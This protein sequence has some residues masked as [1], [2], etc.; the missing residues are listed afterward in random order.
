[1]PSV[2]SV[3]T[4]VVG[5]LS[6][7]PIVA[8]LPLL[9]CSGG[10]LKLSGYMNAGPLFVLHSLFL[11][12]YAG[13]TSLKLVSHQS[14]RTPIAL[15]VASVISIALPT[16]LTLIT[17]S[18]EW[19]DTIAA[20]T[21]IS[22][23]LTNLLHPQGVSF[24]KWT[25]PL[26]VCGDLGTYTNITTIFKGSLPPKGP[27]SSESTFFNPAAALVMQGFGDKAPTT[28]KTVFFPVPEEYKKESSLKPGIVIF[29]HGGAWWSGDPLAPPGPC[30]ADFAFSQGWSYA[31]IEYRLGRNGWSGDVQLEDVKDGIQH[32]LK[33]H[34]E[35][36]DLRKVVVIGSSAGANL[37][38]TASYQ[39]NNEK[40]NIEDP[41]VSGM[42]VA[43]PSTSVKIG[44]GMQSI[45][46]WRGSWDEKEATQRFC[47]D[48]SDCDQK[49]S[50]LEHVS[51]YSPKTVVIHGISDEW[52]TP[53]HSRALVRKL[54][55]N[56]IPY[57][58]IEPPLMPHCIDIVQNS[59]PWQMGMAALTQ[60][61]DSL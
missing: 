40:A 49:L 12:G 10:F 16:V 23:P 7:G 6:F 57:V 58:H 55:R 47:Q 29:V 17:C 33:V 3:W 36:V 48:V 1:M 56:G 26:S 44:T 59:L 13:L 52:Y 21:S 46:K 31:F 60:L 53:H 15:S 50:P 27:V 22:S 2:S 20:Q 34:E 14:I 45:P 42:L 39:L 5:I 24:S 25:S 19:I 61:M 51:K 35:D 41:I 18:P 8:P 32:I 9:G 38:L 28:L 4:F 54:A 37:G 43:A 11:L 30:H